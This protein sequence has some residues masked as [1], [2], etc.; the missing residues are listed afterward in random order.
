MLSFPHNDRTA[1]TRQEQVLERQAQALQGQGDALHRQI[2]HEKRLLAQ[3]EQM[4]AASSYEGR[5]ALS[6]INRHRN[7]PRNNNMITAVPAYGLAM[8]TPNTRFS[9]SEPWALPI[10]MSTTVDPAITLGRVQAQCEVT[11]A[12]MRQEQIVRNGLL[13]VSRSHL[14]FVC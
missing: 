13:A 2:K 8:M 9:F 7:Y 1:K 6:E 11:A 12:L 3:V 14:V 10:G 4:A 5:L